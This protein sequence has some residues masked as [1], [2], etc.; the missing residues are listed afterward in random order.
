M[1]AQKYNRNHT[2]RTI[3]F[4]NITDGRNARA[5]SY[6]PRA[7]LSVGQCRPT[8]LSIASSVPT[9]CAPIGYKSAYYQALTDHYVRP[10]CLNWICVGVCMPHY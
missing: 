10:I 7:G 6:I 1:P 8:P 9:I 3:E 4:S 2:T 5:V